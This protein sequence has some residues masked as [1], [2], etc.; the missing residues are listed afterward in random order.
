MT[1][2]VFRELLAAQD[3]AT[4]RIRMVQ[5]LRP[6]TSGVGVQNIGMGVIAARL[7]FRPESHMERIVRRENITG[8][9]PLPGMNGD[10]P[11]L[12]VIVK[13]FPLVVVGF[14]LNPDTMKPISD[15][16][17]YVQLRHDEHLIQK[18]L[19]R[20]LL[21]VNGNYSLREPG[22]ERFVNVMA[23]DASEAKL[24]RGKVRGL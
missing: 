7:G 18:W 5:S 20:G 1:W 24:F 4:F 11:A 23:T 17:V 21:F 6:G 2:C 16:R 10:P 9:E 19:R 3:S 15:H 13:G 12:K 8:I 14:V 22:I